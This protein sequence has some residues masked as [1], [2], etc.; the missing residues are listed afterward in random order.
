MEPAVIQAYFREMRRVLVPGGR[1]VIHDYGHGG[2]GFTLS[3][4]CAEEVLDLAEGFISR[5][6][7]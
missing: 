5:D 6:S 7:I 3:W 4:G 2:A 1:A